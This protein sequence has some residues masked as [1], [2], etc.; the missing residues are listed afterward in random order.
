MPSHTVVSRS[1]LTVSLIIVLIGITLSLTHSVLATAD[2]ADV[3]VMTTRARFLA[4]ILDKLRAFG[5]SDN[6]IITEFERQYVTDPAIIATALAEA[7][8]IAAAQ[9]AIVALDDGINIDTGTRDSWAE[10]LTA[11]RV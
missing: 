5:V 8:A 6:Q 2:D 1:H 9:R 3:A 11:L 4:P 10:H 7:A